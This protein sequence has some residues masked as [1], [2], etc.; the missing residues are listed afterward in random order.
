MVRPSTQ[1]F[2]NTHPELRKQLD[3][4]QTRNSSSLLS[5]S[6]DSHQHNVPEVV[7][8][9]IGSSRVVSAPNVRDCDAAARRGAARVFEFLTED[10]FRN[11]YD[12]GDDGP[13]IFFEIM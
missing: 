3:S 11:A 7:R 5:E 4:T 8:A 2:V 13:S 9:A 10:N 12:I 1:G 6:L